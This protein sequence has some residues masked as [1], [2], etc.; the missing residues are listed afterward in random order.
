MRRWCFARWHQGAWSGWGVTELD[1][2]RLWRSLGSQLCTPTSFDGS[3]RPQSSA[4]LALL[5]PRPSAFPAHSLAPI[6]AYLPVANLSKLV[7]SKTLYCSRPALMLTLNRIRSGD[8][9]FDGDFPQMGFEELQV[10]CLHN[11]F[12]SHPKGHFYLFHTPI[13]VLSPGSS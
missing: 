9:A 13:G 2:V 7:S 11:S 10:S 1:D 6:K 4:L 3:A 5:L 8:S 12:T